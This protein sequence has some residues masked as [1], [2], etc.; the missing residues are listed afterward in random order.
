MG[1]D[2]LSI[3]HLSI[4][5]NQL[6]QGARI[7]K[8]TQSSKDF[9]Q[10]HL[11]HNRQKIQ[12]LLCTLSE[13]ARV[14]LTNTS[15]A[16]LQ[17]PHTF[18]MLLRKHLLNATIDKVEQVDFERI[19]AIH[20]TC[21]SEFT[22]KQKTLYCEVM[23]KYSNLIL[24][25]DGLIVGAL[26]S[27]P[28][29]QESKRNLLTG[30][31]YA[32]PPKQEK[33][34]PYA[35]ENL[36]EYIPQ[37]VEKSFAN[38]LFYTIAGLSMQSSREVAKYICQ[39]LQLDE[40]D[41][42]SLA[43][44][45]S[46]ILQALERA[47]ADTLLQCPASPS[48]AYVDGQPTAFYPL[49]FDKADKKTFTSM[50]ECIEC[51]YQNTG[52][53]QKL[54]QHRAKCIQFCNTQFKKEEKKLQMLQLQQEKCQNL[55]QNRLYGE[56]ITANIYA[57]KK[58]DSCCTVV[59]Y[60]SENQEKC[61]IALDTKKTPSENAQ[62]YYN[63]YN[64]QKR[65]LVA[66]AEQIAKVE[67]EID[68]W[69]SM[70]QMLAL[71]EEMEDLTEIEQEL[72]E[73]KSNKKQNKPNKKQAQQSKYRKYS[74]ENFTVCVGRNTLQNE[75]LLKESREFDVWLH[76][77]KLTSAHAI[78]FTNRQ[79]V[80]ENV[81]Q[82]TAEIVAYFSS[83]RENGKVSV[84]YCMRKHVKKPPKAKAGFVT[85]TNFKTLLV[86]PNKNESLLEK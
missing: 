56:L 21:S 57:I 64:K 55:E 61:I 11:Y 26:K 24:V 45:D 33:L 13:C 32:L 44:Q 74:I 4:E 66:T 19:I 28:L 15:Y 71:A 41:I 76:A 42:L 51:F 37:F 23:G 47:I 78:V 49:T 69:Q 68:Y 36:K 8:I 39:T 81:L 14:C 65:T 63:R 25:Q 34:S 38:F 18:C 22:V 31:R 3:H 70:I 85:Y 50:L 5:L 82:K 12:L 80:P 10:L 73:N 29:S 77:Q 52:V 16:Y 46:K 30:A 40:K 20:F 6:L 86:V 54:Q 58:G 9:F 17:T 67:Q 48:I 84:D 35:L 59:N 72:F 27:I 43:L 1:I 62:S 53:L 7:D 60:Y 2:G 79:T 83:G 75:K